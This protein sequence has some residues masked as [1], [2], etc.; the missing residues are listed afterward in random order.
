MLTHTVTRRTLLGAGALLGMAALVGCSSGSDDAATTAAP[1]EAMESEGTQAELEGAPTGGGAAA[2]GSTLVVYFSR[3][4]ENYPS[5][6]LEVG[7][8]KVMAGCIAE[9]LGADMYEITPQEA[10]PEGYDECCDVAAVEL[11]ENVRPAIAEELPDVSGY[12]T[13]FIG[14]PIWWGSEP[15]VV[16][17]F[18]DACDLSGKTIVPFTTHAGSGLGSV[19]EN[20]ATHIGDATYLDGLAVEGTAVD[21]AADQIANWALSLGL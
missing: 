21:G 9:A 5:E 16:R 7:H 19:P 18:L 10:H 8:T 14:C 1:V 15:M 12:A 3:A 6:M 17:T 11:R 13:V 20:L 4:G 2:G